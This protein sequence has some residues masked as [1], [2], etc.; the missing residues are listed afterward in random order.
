LKSLILDYSNIYLLA[1]N[2]DLIGHV[3]EETEFHEEEPT[4]PKKTRK[5]AKYYGADNGVTVCQVE[6]NVDHADASTLA[7][8]V[9]LASG[10]G[11]TIWKCRRSSG[12]P[13]FHD[14]EF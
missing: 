3:E 2:S 5:V 14:G 4:K 8:V 6:K 13:I 1:K 9:S 7:K 11:A 10:P 12:F